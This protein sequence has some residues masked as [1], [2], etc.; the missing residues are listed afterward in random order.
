MQR[1]F[2]SVLSIILLFSFAGS[3]FADIKIR[4]K[5]SM[6]GQSFETTKMI[7]GAR[8]RTQQK[9]EMGGGTADYMSQVAT[10]EQCDLRRTVQVNDRKKLYFI[11][12]FAED[13]SGTVPVT[14]P[15]SPQTRRGGTVTINYSVIDTG[16]RELLFGLTA[17]HLKIVQET[18]STA[19]SCGGAQ[20]SKM[21]IDGWF[22]DFSADFNC[23]VE[24]PQTPRG[25]VSKPDCRDRIVY[26]RSGP[27]NPGF[28]LN[29]TT[30]FFDE[31]GN[32]TVS[33]TTET[34]ELS[35]APL[36]PSLFDVP[37]DY[38]LAA[39]PDELYS[40]PSMTDILRQQ[41]TDENPPL[42]STATA[43]N[44]Q[45]NIT[46]GSEAKIN[47]GETKKY[48]QDLLRLR[49]FNPLA[50]GAFD[51]VLNVEIKKVRESSAS[52]VGGI[53]GKV[54]GIDTKTAKTEVELVLT[55]I[56]SDSNTQIGQT[57]IIQKFDGSPTDAVRSAIADGLEK[58]L[59]KIVN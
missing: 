26:K 15:T 58:V 1:I 56:K 7:K 8:Q 34:I 2:K 3:V 37:A 54:T 9:S 35:R 33:Q 47:Q 11:E 14:R 43:K 55:L 48:L 27:A 25:Q 22:A 44:V 28:M 52:K 19:D 40:M 30:R 51:Y 4:Q 21:E 57:R 10:I 59:F 23:P 18:V 5:I 16:E 17:R 38:R 24:I 12:P 41:Q 13:S 32:V 20:Q 42:P 50:G 39:S 46:Y 53:F 49:N 29:G 31:N 6:G 36:A 45:L